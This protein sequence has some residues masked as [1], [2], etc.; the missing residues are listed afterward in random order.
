MK[1]TIKEKIFH[2]FD[3]T[4][5]ELQQLGLECAR[6]STDINELKDGAKSVASDY[7]AKVDQKDSQR[8]LVASKLNSGYEMREVEAIVELDFAI[9][10]K[11]YIHPQTF[12]VLKITDMSPAD[13]QMSLIDESE[14]DRP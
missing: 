3:F 6:L 5:S 9:G 4:P 10:K 7:K 11:C 1:K 12:E 2:K 14:F 8:N 13:R